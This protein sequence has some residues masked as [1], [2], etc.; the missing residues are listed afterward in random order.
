MN[1]SRMMCSHLSAYKHR[2]FGQMGDGIFR[3]RGKEIPFAH[4]LPFKDRQKNILEVYRT[5]FYASDYSSILF[6]RYFHHLNSS[7]AMCINLFYP[8]IHE[9]ALNLVMQFLSIDGASDLRARFEKESDAEV[10]ERRTSFDFHIQY[11]GKCDVFFE[12]KYTE[13]DF[14]KAKYDEAHRQKFKATYLPLLK[15]SLYLVEECH[16]DAI[17]LRHYQL[18]RNLVHLA[19]NVHVV[20]LFPSANTTVAQQAAVA[21]DRFLTDAGRAQLKIIFLEDLIAYLEQHCTGESLQAYWNNFREKYLP[22]LRVH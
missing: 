22:Q 17:F 20:L 19:P 2:V 13:R 14:G 4:I 9:N 16:D 5:Q 10:A 15:R 12:V 1:F 11:S 6:H 21:Y 8:L 7:Q 3:Y 18:L